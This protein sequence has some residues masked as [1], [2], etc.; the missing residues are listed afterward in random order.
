MAQALLSVGATPGATVDAD[1]YDDDDDEQ[2]D[3]GGD[4]DG[5]AR[6]RGGL[7]LRASTARLLEREAGLFGE[8]DEDE[9]GDE[10]DGEGLVAPAG[11]VASPYSAHSSA[12]AWLRRRVGAEEL[13]AVVAEG[14]EAVGEIAP[15][16]DIQKVSAAT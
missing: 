16:D 8:E 9:D 6:S 14:K 12:S 1:D 7:R 5:A 11:S 10:E 3:G 4:E 2:Q 13:E 15:A